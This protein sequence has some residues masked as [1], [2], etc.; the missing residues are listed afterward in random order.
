MEEDYIWNSTKLMQAS[1]D[2]S[3]YRN[4]LAYA[5]GNLVIMAI[6]SGGF[7]LFGLIEK[8]YLLLILFWIVFSFLAV[9]IH[10]YVFRYAFRIVNLGAWVY[11]YPIVFT[12]G[13]SLNEL[14]NNLISVNILWYPLIGFCSL[15]IGL[16][17]EKRH[18]L[19]KKL[20]SRPL[21]ILGIVFLISFPFLWLI[22]RFNTISNEVELFLGPGFALILTA[23]CTSYSMA[24][25]E[26]QVINN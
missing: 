8:A 9:M 13:Y 15:I 10:V 24:Q 12:I 19:S 3:V 7:I 21:L 20:F 26:K 6:L 11:V 14:L 1:V 2:L 25:A 18:Y 22:L 4:T 17:I 16:T 23:L 5:L